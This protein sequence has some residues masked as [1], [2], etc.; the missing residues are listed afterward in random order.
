[1]TKHLPTGPNIIGATGGSGTRVV[2]RI[3]QRGGMFIGTHHNESQDALDFK[4]YFDHW[5]NPFIQS[6]DCWTP[7]L[8]L[9]LQAEMSQ[10]LHA[11]TERHCAPLTAETQL[12]ARK[13]WGWKAPRSIYLLPF[14]HSQFPAFRFLHVVRDGRDMAYSLNQNQLSSHGG[15]FLNSTEMNWSQPLQSIALWSRINL[16]A[17]NYG[18]ENL[19]GQ[20]MRVRFEDLCLEPI[21]TIRRI[22]DFFG[23]EGDPE[24]ISQLEVTPPQSIGRWQRLC[25]SKGMLVEL[26]QIGRMALEKFGY[27]VPE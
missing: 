7:P 25:Q 17:A 8:P 23:L 13:A 14:W 15:A 10:D 2:A 9:D 26:N 16:L 24:T 3:A 19:R 22:L 27:W 12:R 11:V 1:M 21:Q 6:T 20:Y 18:E 5:I 4:A